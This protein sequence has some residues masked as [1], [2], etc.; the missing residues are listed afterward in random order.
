[1]LASFASSASSMMA[2]GR[3]QFAL[4]TLR[5]PDYKFQHHAMPFRRYAIISSAFSAF[6]HMPFPRRHDFLSLSSS[7]PSSHFQ[8]SKIPCCM[9]ARSPICL[10][11]GH[12]PHG[13][14]TLSRPKPRFDDDELAGRS[15]RQYW[16]FRFQATSLTPE[17]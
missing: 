6:I 9:P 15:F 11:R 7:L 12:A 1:M 5:M 13:T 3:P 10:K 4:P 16:P 2:I 17:K 14:P 8:I